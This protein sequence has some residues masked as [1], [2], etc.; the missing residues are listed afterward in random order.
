LGVTSLATLNGQT[1]APVDASTAYYVKYGA[2]ASLSPLDDKKIQLDSQSLIY[3]MTAGATKTTMSV[4]WTSVYKLTDTDTT[5]R[6]VT[7]ALPYITSNSNIVAKTPSYP[8]LSYTVSQTTTTLTPSAIHEIVP[9]TS[10]D[11]LTGDDADPI[12]LEQTYQKAHALLPSDTTT[13]YHYNYT[14]TLKH[15]N[16]DVT[17][18]CAATTDPV[19]VYTIPSG[20]EGSGLS[21]YGSSFPTLEAYGTTTATFNFYSTQKLVPQQITYGYWSDGDYAKDTET[22][23]GSFEPTETTT[24]LA[25]CEKWSMTYSYPVDLFKDNVAYQFHKEMSASNPPQYYGVTPRLPFAAEDT[26]DYT[27]LDLLYTVPLTGG[28]SFTLAQ[29]GSITSGANTSYDPYVFTFYVTLTV[30]A[31]YVDYKSATIE[32]DTGSAYILNNTFKKSGSSAYTY[33]DPLTN[34]KPAAVFFQYCTSATPSYRN[35]YDGFNNFLAVLFSFVV[36]CLGLMFL[37]QSSLYYDVYIVV[38]IS[39]LLGLIAMTVVLI[40][41][42]SSKKKDKK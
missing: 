6:N 13:L 26:L 25:Y 2:N 27:F 30:R 34:T 1:A 3:D 14:L 12:A 29:E 7:F 20:V 33:T 18:A 5:A 40:V 19:G 39:L 42:N 37:A 4:P 15:A 36:P 21:F 41:E 38:G 11:W 28:T 24:F 32:A 9:N 10:L 35:S 22:F 17:L 31:N 23:T 16:S 8:S